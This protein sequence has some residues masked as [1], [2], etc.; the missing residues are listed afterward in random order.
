[1]GSVQPGPQSCSHW[2]YSYLPQHSFLQM[3]GEWRVVIK[4]LLRQSECGLEKNFQTQRTA[5]KSL[6]R[7]KS[8]D[9]VGTSSAQLLTG[10]GGS[11]VFVS[12]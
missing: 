9:K 2:D 7:T 10:Q 6:L 4:C 3:R 12:W 1:M 8:R 5:G 11:T